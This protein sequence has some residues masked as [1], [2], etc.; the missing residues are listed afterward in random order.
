MEVGKGFSPFMRPH[1]CLVGGRDW[2]GFCPPPV[3]LVDNY[4]GSNPRG[5]GASSV[6]DSISFEHLGHDGDF[7]LGSSNRGIADEDERRLISTVSHD[8]GGGGGDG[9]VWPHPATE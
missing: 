8:L 2:P 1:V 9:M 4:S 5:A 3:P 7:P 6:R